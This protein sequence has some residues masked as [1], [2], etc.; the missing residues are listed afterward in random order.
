[1]HQ[2]KRFGTFLGKHFLALPFL[3]S[4]F[5]LYL[6]IA[7]PFGGPIMNETWVNIP[8]LHETVL[9]ITVGDM[10]VFLSI[11]VLFIEIMKS[12]NYTTRTMI[13]HAL[14]LLLLLV[15]IILFVSVPACGTSTFLTFTLMLLVD[16]IAGY[17]VTQAVAGRS[18]SLG[19]LT[20][21]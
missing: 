9:A 20:G 21:N 19:S 15:S 8:L 14:S 18:L 12:T 17:N 2:I 4:V 13:D 16:V 6:L 10:I 3:F 7:L 11:L 1:M 5:I